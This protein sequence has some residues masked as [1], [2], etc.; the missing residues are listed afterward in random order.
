MNPLA[1]LVGRR[2]ITTVGVPRVNKSDLT[3][4]DVRYCPDTVSAVDELYEEQYV[5]EYADA[6]IELGYD[7]ENQED[8]LQEDTD[9]DGEPGGVDD[10][11]QDAYLEAEGE[12]GEYDDD[13]EVDEEGIEEAG[14]E[15]GEDYDDQGVDS[16]S[17]E[18]EVI[19]TVVELF[20][21]LMN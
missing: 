7:V 17:G 4:D 1:V 8:Y 12:Q 16:D 10:G 18:N 14:D 19:S 5:W 15:Q 6:G 13:Q 9:I 21:W 11:D 2:L 20:D 3:Y